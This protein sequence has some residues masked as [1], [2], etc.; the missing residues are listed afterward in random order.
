MAG[1]MEGEEIAEAQDAFYDTMMYQMGVHH[2]RLFAVFVTSASDGCEVLDRLERMEGSCGAQCLEIVE[3]AE[4][5][6]SGRALWTLGLLL[7]T[8]GEADQDYEWYDSI[9]EASFSASLD[10]TDLLDVYDRAACKA[11]CL[12][13][14]LMPVET[15]I[16]TG[17]SVKVRHWREERHL[18]GRYEITFED[19]TVEGSFDAEYCPGLFVS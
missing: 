1:T 13:E 3:I 11:A 5:H 14:D 6:L 18:R 2:Y 4:D 7:A 16:A 10:R 19:G 15:W 9:E 8:T 12:D 17:G